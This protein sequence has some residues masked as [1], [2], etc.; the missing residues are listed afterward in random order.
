MASLHPQ[1]AALVE[2][3]ARSQR[4]NAHLLPV[5]EARRHFDRECAAAEA[6]EAVAQ[7]TNMMVPTNGGSIP[8]RVYRP[9]AGRLGALIYLHGGGWVLGSIDSHDTVCRALA[10]A[11]GAAVISVGYRRAPEHRFPTAVEDAYVG[12]T[13][14][15]G[16]AAELE[17][18]TGLLAV[19]GDSAGGNLAAAVALLARERHGPAIALQVLVY[20]V[21]TV[22]LERGFD[23]EHEGVVLQR[24]ELLWHQRHYL[25]DSAEGRSPLVS[26]L[27]HAEL[28]GLPPALVIT[29]GCDP[30]HPQGHLYAEALRRAA[31]PVEHIHYPGMIHGFFQMPGTLD[32]A[33]DAVSRVATALKAAGFTSNPEEG[34]VDQ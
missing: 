27:D 14:T 3:S 33:R 12:L 10:N 7:V 16:H 8:V 4:P 24:A 25:T 5:P 26:P 6:G 2:Q 1:A 19:G 22:D 21:T 20:P 28:G 18:D 17:I 32:D 11:S 30:L 9:A 34:V 23:D 15:V 13:W 29:A 31:V